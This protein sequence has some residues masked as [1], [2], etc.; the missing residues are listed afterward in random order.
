M[1]QATMTEKGPLARPLDERTNKWPR[2]VLS[3]IAVIFLVA[4]AYFTVAS[5]SGNRDSNILTETVAPE[6]RLEALKLLSSDE[7]QRLIS[8]EADA[9]KSNP[10]DQAALKNLTLLLRAEGDQ[11]RAERLAIL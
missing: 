6:N 7:R 4:A 3:A 11:E 1:V 8:R 9:L 2:M 5:L 10:L